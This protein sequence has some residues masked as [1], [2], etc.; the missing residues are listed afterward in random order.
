MKRKVLTSIVAVVSGLATVI[1]LSNGTDMILESTGVF[2]S[3]SEQRVQGFII[4]WMAGLALF[5]RL[6]FLLVGGYVVAHLA[7]IN[8]IR[9]VLIL[10]IIGTVLGILGAIAT[11]EF[12]PSWFLLSPVILGIPCVWLGGKIRVNKS[13]ATKG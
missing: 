9:H 10:G 3:V 5:Y 1:I 4:P 2:P 13:I 8:P 12:A 6:I 11:W 7:P